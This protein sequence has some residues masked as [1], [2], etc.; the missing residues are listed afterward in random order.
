M[1]YSSVCLLLP[2]VALE[3]P[4]SITWRVLLLNLSSFLC[5]NY[6]NQITII[7]DHVN[8]IHLSTY[9][10]FRG[11]NISFWL[12]GFYLLEAMRWET[13]HLRNMSY[14]VSC[15]QCMT[16]TT[17]Y[18]WACMGIVFQRMRT[19]RLSTF[20]RWCWHVFQSIYIYQLLCVLYPP[21]VQLDSIVDYACTVVL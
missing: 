8:I 19:K 20:D 3:V 5:E 17:V 9:I 14:L 4:F 15:L 7:L 13:H 12:I 18:Y 11:C 10:T 1:Y 21:R 6:T 2:I 16:N